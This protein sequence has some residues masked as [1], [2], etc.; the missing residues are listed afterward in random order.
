MIVKDSNRNE[1]IDDVD[2]NYDLKI[3]HRGIEKYKR[4][5]N[6]EPIIIPHKIAMEPIRI[7]SYNEATN[8]VTVSLNVHSMSNPFQQKL[9]INF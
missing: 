2:L 3:L 8:D 9:E 1:I 7:T 6:S 5:S 4:L